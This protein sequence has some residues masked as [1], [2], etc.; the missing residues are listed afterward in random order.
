MFVII[1]IR[2]KQAYEQ[3]GIRLFESLESCHPDPPDDN[4]DTL[5]PLDTRERLDLRCFLNLQAH[6][7]LQRRHVL[8][9]VIVVRIVA[10]RKS[11]NAV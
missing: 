9:H 10:S 6:Q 8:G 7:N 11:L 4:L 5:S 3:Q 2:C 1:P